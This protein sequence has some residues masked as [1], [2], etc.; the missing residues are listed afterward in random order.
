[1]DRGYRSCIKN[2]VSLFGT[3]GLD[4]VSGQFF[5]LQMINLVY[6]SGRTSGMLNIH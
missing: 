2:G 4:S 6:I 3:A 5:T 1:M